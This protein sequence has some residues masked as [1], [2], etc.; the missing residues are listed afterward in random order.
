MFAETRYSGPIA[1]DPPE[2]ILGLHTVWSANGYT[3]ARDVGNDIRIHGTRTDRF[4]RG[5]GEAT[6]RLEYL[7]RLAHARGGALLSGATVTAD[8]VRV[9]EALQRRGYEV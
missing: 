8:A 2:D 7:A 4:A 9:W 1:Y 6:A 3:D 5:R